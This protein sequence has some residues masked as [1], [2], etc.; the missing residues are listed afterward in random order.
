MFNFLQASEDFM[1]V[2]TAVDP[3]DFHKT[4]LGM[5]GPLGIQPSCHALLC[6]TG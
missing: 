4:S 3:R 6:D 2:T 1:K 5:T